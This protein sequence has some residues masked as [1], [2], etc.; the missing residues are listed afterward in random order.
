MKK[1]GIKVTGGELRKPVRVID[2]KRLS[3]IAVI[4]LVAVALG[5]G[6]AIMKANNIEFSI[7]PPPPTAE[8]KGDGSGI[9]EE[10]MDEALNTYDLD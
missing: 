6:I 4:V 7:L 9:S 5:L 3:I 8:P 1:H 10:L 2:R